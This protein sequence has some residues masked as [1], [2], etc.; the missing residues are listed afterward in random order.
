MPAYS[1]SRKY[2]I[3]STQVDL[4]TYCINQHTKEFSP[5]EDNEARKLLAE[6]NSGGE[7]SDLPISDP[8][9]PYY[10]SCDI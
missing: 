9:D 3:T 10:N 8:S 2:N 7:P 1:A 4:I 5:L 6:L